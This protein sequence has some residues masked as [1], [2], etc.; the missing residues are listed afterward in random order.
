MPCHPQTSLGHGWAGWQS[1][2]PICSPSNLTGSEPRVESPPQQLGDGG[3]F[4]RALE[5]SLVGGPAL[6]ETQWPGSPL[7]ASLAHLV[8]RSLSGLHLPPLTTLQTLTPPIPK[9]L[10]SQLLP[11]APCTTM[12]WSPISWSH[13]EAPSPKLARVRWGRI[14]T[15]SL[16]LR[17]EQVP[18]GQ[19]RLQ[20]WLL[21]LCG[22]TCLQ[23]SF[24][25]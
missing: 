1:S 7:A 5:C 23:S 20:L 10:S 15:V 8:P 17:W 11:D 21:V 12:P 13:P 14:L 18:D 9:L 6:L 2:C 3:S 4:G 19:T 25:H 24:P 16:G 22:E